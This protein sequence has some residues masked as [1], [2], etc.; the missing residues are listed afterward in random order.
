MPSSPLYGIFAG[1]D[2]FPE[3]MSWPSWIDALVLTANTEVQYNIPNNARYIRMSG[4]GNFY[5]LMDNKA[6]IPTSD[7]LD[8]SAPLLVLSG[9]A[10]LR[11]LGDATYLSFIAAGNCSV[12]LEIYGDGDIS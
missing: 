5:V 10:D 7:I 9:D 4:T 6:A 11:E 3:G 12:C 2:L 1:G 8:G